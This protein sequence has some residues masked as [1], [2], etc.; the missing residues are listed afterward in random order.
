MTQMV[1]SSPWFSVSWQES[2]HSPVE[3]ALLS[4]LSSPLDTAKHGTLHGQWPLLNSLENELLGIRGTYNLV[5]LWKGTEQ[6]PR[7]PLA[8]LSA[9]RRVPFLQRGPWIRGSESLV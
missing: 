5:W 3:N 4:V 2:L 7:Q 9:V 1:I 6:T 8:T